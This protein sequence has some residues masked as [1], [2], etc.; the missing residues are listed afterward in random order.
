MDWNTVKLILRHVAE[1]LP[2]FAAAV[3]SLGLARLVFLRSTSF[4]SQAHLF[5]QPNPAYAVAFGGFL[6]GA[7]LALAGTFFGGREG[8][9]L[10]AAG[11]LLIEGVLVVAL[12]RVSIL[13]NDRFILHSFSIAKEIGED[14]NLGVGFC[15]AG[16]SIACGTILNGAM[17]GY[18][19]DFLHGLRDI[20]LF[21]TVAQLAL[22]VAC[23]AYRK[24]MRYDVHRLI[25]FDDNAAV[26]LGFGGFLVGMGIVLRSSL[27]HAGKGTLGAELAI[28]ALLALLGA[29]LLVTVNAVVLRLLFPK[30]SYQEEVEMN[31]NLAVAAVAACVTVAAALFLASIVQRLPP[32]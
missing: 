6:L 19:L 29:G 14:R 12:L 9:A 2:L 7:G 22:V 15:V 16:S 26:G 10:E 1:G 25:E 20:A 27:V 32:Q 30:T 18:S 24:S 23:A 17:T 4:N 13:I 11:K 3:I 31:G 21:W 28:S 8:G 5:D